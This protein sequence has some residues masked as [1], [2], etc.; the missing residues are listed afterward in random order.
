M[1]S[2]VPYDDLSPPQTQP[3]IQNPR[4]QTFKHVQRQDR[5]PPSKKRKVLKQ[6]EPHKQYFNDS[7]NEQRM[8][9]DLEE[10]K[11]DGEESRE[12]TY[13]EIWDDSALVD[14]WN[15]ATEEYEVRSCCISRLWVC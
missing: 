9:D 3:T 13:D 1:R 4:P 8:N 15:A 6:P 11:T 14:A 5:Q 12:L 7:G 2:L 10:S